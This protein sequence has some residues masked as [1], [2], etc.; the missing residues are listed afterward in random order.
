M[1]RRKHSKLFL[2]LICISV[3]GLTYSI[4]SR[5]EDVLTP[6]EEKVLESPTQ[7][8]D[9]YEEV[10]SKYLRKATVPDWASGFTVVP[11]AF[12]KSD[13]RVGGAL[14]GEVMPALYGLLIN[15]DRILFKYF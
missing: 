3:A 7:D 6:E 5:A 15:G 2:T 12:K 1:N 13:M 9:K 11:N 10:R 8:F 14:G 4:V